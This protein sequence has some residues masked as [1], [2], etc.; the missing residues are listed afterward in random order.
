MYFV[1]Y[2]IQYVFLYFLLYL[3]CYIRSRLWEYSHDSYKEA[4]DLIVCK[5]ILVII[6]VLSD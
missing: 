4:F 2:F 6:T 3:S 1:M 5:R